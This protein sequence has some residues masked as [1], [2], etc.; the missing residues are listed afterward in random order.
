[1]L[2]IGLLTELRS[3]PVSALSLPQCCVGPHMQFLMLV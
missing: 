1:M 3:L 2:G